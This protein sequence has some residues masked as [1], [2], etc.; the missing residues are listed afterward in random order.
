MS[1]TDIRIRVS[2]PIFEVLQS[3][4]HQLAYAHAVGLVKIEDD[5]T[6]ALP[7]IPRF[8]LISRRSELCMNA[9]RI[10][11]MMKISKVQDANDRQ[12]L[13]TM[14]IEPEKHF[15]RKA[16]FTYDTNTMSADTREAFEAIKEYVSDVDF[17]WLRKEMSQRLLEISGRLSD[18]RGG[19]DD[20]GTLTDV[21]REIREI[22]SE[23]HL[24][25]HQCTCVPREDKS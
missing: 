11:V 9:W 22:S 5:I 10:P 20:E 14:L 25:C 1:Y 23:L 16:T 2:T 6:N 19:S 3:G 15:G 17:I 7:S 13:A 21:V 4:D 8:E 18:L 12:I 24:N